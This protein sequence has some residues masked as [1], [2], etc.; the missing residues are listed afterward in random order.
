MELKTKVTAKKGSHQITITREFELTI[1]LLFKAYIDSSLFEQW[2]GTRL[3]KFDCVPHGSYRFET[4]DQ[5]GNVVFSANGTFHEVI[6]NKRITRTFEMENSS[7]PV[8]LEFL[9]F[10]QLS[11][12]TSQLNMQ[13]IFRSGE[14]RDQL[15]KMPFAQGLNYAHNRLEEILNQ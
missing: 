13:M 8:Q 6:N 14:F 10:E 12:N 1:D 7:F 9:E 4:S 15:L 3:T 11:A 5:D 2:M